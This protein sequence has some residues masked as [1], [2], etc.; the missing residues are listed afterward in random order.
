VPHKAIAAGKTKAK[1]RQRRVLPADARGESA[2][3]IAARE[4]LAEGEVALRLHL[5]QQLDP[6]HAALS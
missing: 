6:R 2:A 1:P 3:Q 4:A 5:S